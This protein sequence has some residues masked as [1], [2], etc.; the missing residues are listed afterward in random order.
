MR[1]F[2]YMT[3]CVG[4]VFGLV[5]MASA[6]EMI[7]LG[8]GSSIAL[9]YGTD[10]GLTL[11]WTIN[12][13]LNGYAQSLEVGG[14]FNILFA[15]VWTEEDWINADD[16]VVAPLTAT[17]D[18]E[19]PDV[20]A[21]VPGGV[22]GYS[23]PLVLMGGFITIADFTQGWNL[24]WTDPVTVPFGNGGSLLVDLSNA[25]FSQGFWMGP[26]GNY[27]N[28]AQIWATVTLDSAPVPN[29]VPEPSTMLLLGAGLLGMV[30]YGRKRMKK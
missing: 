13:A 1:K 2:I 16:T 8:G 18:F 28:G 10:S 14:S 30:A 23:Q 5:G 9:G 22:Q 24:T 17:L 3:L 4:L 12:P 29:A 21:N 15:T 6:A 26:D 19:A 20:D 11:N 27:S 25:T 7:E